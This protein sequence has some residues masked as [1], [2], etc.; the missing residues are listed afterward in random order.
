[1]SNLKP[2]LS[3]SVRNPIGLRALRDELP[4]S[5]PPEI[6]E[7]AWEGINRALAARNPGPLQ[8]STNPVDPESDLPDAVE[9]RSKDPE[10]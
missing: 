8:A 6:S 3:A 7:E 1:M 9:L 2:M 5:R 4:S 10:E